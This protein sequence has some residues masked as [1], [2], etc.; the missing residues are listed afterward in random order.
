MGKGTGN[1]IWTRGTAYAGTHQP[2]HYT[3]KVH[4]TLGGW[5]W[6]E[7]AGRLYIPTRF[8]GY[9]AHPAGTG[10]LQ[11][12]GFA[13][14]SYP[15]VL[16]KNAAHTT[17]G[18]QRESIREVS[19]RFTQHAVRHPIGGCGR[20]IPY[21]Q[22]RMEMLQTERA[23]ERT[24]CSRWRNRKETDY[25]VWRSEYE[26]RNLFQAGAGNRTAQGWSLWAEMEWH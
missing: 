23:E 6:T 11:A 24:S 18:R 10:K 15:W 5:C 17:F 22:S 21:S 25:S 4:R 3:G 2:Q 12:D 1:S 8:A 7:E 9:P 19:R 20:G 26:V 14:R 16:R 13:K